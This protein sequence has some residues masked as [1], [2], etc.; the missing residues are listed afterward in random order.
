[1]SDRTGTPPTPRRST[2]PARGFAGTMRLLRLALRRDRVRIAVWAASI[3]G[4]VGASAASIYGLYGTVQQ[5]MEYVQT[6]L[7]NAAMIIQSGPGYGLDHP[8]TGAIFMNETA[9]WSIILVAVFGILMTTRHTRLEEETARS[10]LVRSAPVGRYAGA[11]AGLLAVL[12]AQLIVA[13]TVTLTVIGFGYGPAGA[14]AFGASLVAA[15]IAFAAIALVTAQVAVSS[16]AA[17]GLGLATLGVAFVVRAYGDVTTPWVSWLS[18]IHW[19]QAIR[20]YA[21]ERWLV[22]ALPAALTAAM[23]L[24]AASLAEHRDFGGGLLTQHPGRAEATPT[25]YPLL[26]LAIR[27]HRGAIV[28]W[29]V[30]IAS[31]AFFLGV[32]A[33]QVEQMAANNPA[34]ND[35]LTQIG[36]GS[37]TDTFLATGLLIVGLLAAGFAISAALRMHTE[38]A[39][40]RVDPLLATPVGRMRWAASHLVVAMGALVALMT[41]GGIANGL[42]AALVLDDGSKVLTMLGAA[43]TMTSGVAVLGAI[44]FL[45]CAA[46]PRLALSAW[47][48]LMVAM[49]ASML[50]RVLDLPGWMLDLSPYQHVPALPAAQFDVVP[51]ILLCLVAVGLVGAGLMILPHRDV[52]RA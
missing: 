48:P 46:A 35:V 32:V 31:G 16:R 21:G 5:R 27:L 12:V 39:A 49:V 19:A 15:G 6:T 8:T 43:L 38:E 23:L 44:A 22:L 30:G 7:G 42:G 33:D 41:V 47:V 9:I 52:G 2:E 28:G 17:N 34:M 37:I 50:G 24:A 11:A 25:R 45:L 20:A 26:A 14:I 10:E 4:V 1:M 3:A 18:P 40:G 51:V 36:T 13:A 29:S